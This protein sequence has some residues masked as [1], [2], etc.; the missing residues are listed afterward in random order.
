MIHPGAEGRAVRIVTAYKYIAVITFVKWTFYLEERYC[1]S[2]VFIIGQE[3]VFHQIITVRYSYR[4][5]SASMVPNF[6]C[7]T[8]TIKSADLM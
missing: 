7:L 5:Y 3:C 1:E 2:I 8:A 6:I 4:G